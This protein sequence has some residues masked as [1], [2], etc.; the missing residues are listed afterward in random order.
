MN[1]LASQT[2]FIHTVDYIVKII[3]QIKNYFVDQFNNRVYNTIT[4]S[5]D[6][7]V[8]C[9]RMI[10]TELEQRECNMLGSNLQIIDSVNKPNYKVTDGTY[11]LHST[12]KCTIYVRITKKYISIYT[13][14]WLCWTFTIDQFRQYVDS[15]YS[16]HNSVSQ[17]MLFYNSKHGEWDVPIVKDPRLFENVSITESMQ[18]VL[19]DVSSFLHNKKYYDDNGFPFRRGYML[20]GPPGTGKS[21]I[22]EIISFTH[23][24]PVFSITLNAK[25]MNDETLIGLFSKVPPH[26]IIVIDEFG[27]QLLSL[28]DNKTA[29]VKF[30][31]ILSSIDGPQRLANG[32]IVILTANSDSFLST[33]QRELLIRKGR[34]DKIFHLV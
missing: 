33:N 14:K 26:S 32:V 24:M 19:D 34:I 16:K 21:S 23:K 13:N 5:R 20:I 4:F 27:E 15:L 1:D 8:Q 17:I 2:F 18:T 10:L 30:S 29:C 31:G 25:D 7:N 12:D 3:T 6:Q 22:V 9:E 11:L 28:S